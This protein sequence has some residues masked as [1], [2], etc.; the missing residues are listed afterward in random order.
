[1]S[2]SVPELLAQFEQRNLKL[3]LAESLTGGL[4][5]AVVVA[6]PGAS[7]VLLGTVVAYQSSLKSELLGVSSALIAQSGVIN[8]EVAAQMAAGVRDRLAKG[9]QI[10]PRQVVGVATTGVAGPDSQ[11]GA[12][13]GLVYVGVAG[14]LGDIED[15]RVYAHQFEGDRESVRAQTVAA[16]L[17]DLAEYLTN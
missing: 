3:A 15:A 6:V 14:F 2:A 10:D 5:S 1:M 13:P 16:A 17:Q 12:A 11:D 9:C 7:K 4:L 8:P